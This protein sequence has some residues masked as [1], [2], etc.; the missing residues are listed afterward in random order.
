MRVV[1]TYNMVVLPNAQIYFQME[2]FRT[3]AGKTVG[4]GDKILL[5]V[6]HKN[7]LN[8]QSLTKEELYPIA[9]EGVVK[10]ISKDGYCMVETGSRMRILALSQKEGEP[11]LL[12]TETV[13]DVDDL[14]RTDA[15]KKLL[16]IKKELKELA[17]RL[18]GGQ[19]LEGMIESHKSI[20]EVAC[21]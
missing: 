13:Y 2:H 17:S 1:P 10:E 7:E 5:A 18:R 6:L 9:V 11:L 14:D 15:E 8:T 19:F 12:E 21:I 20:Q 4:E 3:L 16:E